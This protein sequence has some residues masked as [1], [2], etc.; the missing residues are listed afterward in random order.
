[1]KKCAIC[2]REISFSSYAGGTFC[3][4]ECFHKYYWNTFVEL[5]DEP[6]IARINGNHYVISD[7]SDKS[8]FR[9]FNGDRIVVKFFDGRIVETT[10]LWQQGA[11]PAEYRDELKDNAEFVG[12]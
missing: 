8:G 10:N 11:I 7:E 2:G 4:T 1:M 5:K 12:A 9:G 6:N 3:S